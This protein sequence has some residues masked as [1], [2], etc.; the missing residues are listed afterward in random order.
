MGKLS[1]ILIISSICAVNFLGGCTIKIFDN[2]N[3]CNAYTYKCMEVD[4]F[5]SI[6]M[7]V[8]TVNVSI[9]ESDKC[10]IEYNL[11]LPS[12]HAEEQN[13]IVC[14]S[15]Q[16]VL[17]FK[18]PKDFIKVNNTDQYVNIFV[19]PYKKLNNCNINMNVGN[20]HCSEK[21]EIGDN[22]N[23]NCNVGDIKISNCK[24]E[25][26]KITNGVGDINIS[27]NIYGKDIISV[28]VGNVK[29]N[30][31]NSLQDYSYFLK[32]GVGKIIINGQ[33][34]TSNTITG[35]VLEGN[36]FHDDRRLEVNVNT[37]NISV[38]EL[39]EL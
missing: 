35:D 39:N 13:N 11:L 37:G 7:D 14:E 8:D 38:N 34:S 33:K 17:T 10:K 12:S 28:G 27:G 15:K 23:I 25:N 24:S 5:D 36:S 18:L 30:L 22:L 3:V 21:I 31:L 6:Q 32:S 9:K 26:V 16:G 20:L 19:S 1:L 4:E 2:S 29:L